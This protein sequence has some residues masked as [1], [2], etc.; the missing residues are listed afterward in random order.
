MTS[1][2]TVFEA[3]TQVKSTYMI[4]S[5]LK[6]RKKEKK[7]SKSKKSLDKS[8]PKRWFRKWNSSC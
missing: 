6:I 4:K 3:A 2:F 1:S 7:I 5:W 8:S